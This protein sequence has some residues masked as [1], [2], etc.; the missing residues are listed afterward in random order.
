[1]S[2]TGFLARVLP[3]AVAGSAAAASLHKSSFARRAGHIDIPVPGR[4]A[5]AVRR[6]EQVATSTA[7]NFTN[8]ADPFNFNTVN[9]YGD[10]QV[11]YTANVTVDGQ[12]YEVS[13]P[14]LCIWLFSLALLGTTRHW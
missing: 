2:P 4:M 6:Q 3:F 9:L 12:S 1:M 5:N 13:R 11:I 7:M 14:P 8:V 10:N